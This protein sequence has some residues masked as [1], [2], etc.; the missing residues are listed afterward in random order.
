MAYCYNYSISEKIA[1]DLLNSQVQNYK[2][3]QI[4]DRQS[5]GN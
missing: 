1:K 2:K 3:K 5:Y 4:K